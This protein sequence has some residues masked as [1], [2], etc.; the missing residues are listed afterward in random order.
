MT[1]LCITL[2]AIVLSIVFGFVMRDWRIAV[3][4]S[5]LCFTG[6][7][8]A[9]ASTGPEREAQVIRG[10]IDAGRLGCGAAVAK[11]VELTAEQRAWCEGRK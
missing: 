5:A 3:L 11:R 6:Y 10:A 2:A 4:M 8:S 1:D 7:V 9:C